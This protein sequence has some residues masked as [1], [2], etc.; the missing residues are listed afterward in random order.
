MIENMLSGFHMIKL[1]ISSRKNFVKGS[2]F[3]IRSITL[4]VLNI[5]IL[6]LSLMEIR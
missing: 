1:E 3:K 5:N 4:F 6:R 2:E